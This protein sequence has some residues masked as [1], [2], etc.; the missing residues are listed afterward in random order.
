MQQPSYTAQ[1]LK[2]LLDG[3]TLKSSDKHYSNANQYFVEI[4]KQGIELIEEWIPNKQS[5]GYHKERRL[6]PS[7]E[8]MK[9]AL[10]LYFKLTGKKY[11]F[12]EEN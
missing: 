3:K 11:T 10:R 8:N 6:N 9:K 5:R 7:I 1:I 2:E 4:K 12:E